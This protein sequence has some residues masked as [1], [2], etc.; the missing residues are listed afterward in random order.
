M[1]GYLAKIWKELELNTN[2]TS[3][4]IKP[5]GYETGYFD[6]KI[7]AWTGLIGMVF[8]KEIDVIVSEVTVMEERYNAVDFLMP[9]I[10][11][12]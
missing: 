2:F 8:R 11:T 3:T 1:N 5:H 9:I 4:C 6:K 7:K 12:R 10:T